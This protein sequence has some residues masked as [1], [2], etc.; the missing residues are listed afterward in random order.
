MKDEMM[1]LRSSIDGKRD[2]TSPDQHD[3][4]ILMFDN[5][6]HLGTATIFTEFIAYNLET[7]SEEKMQDIKNIAVPY[8]SVGLLEV[9]W[10]PLAGP[11]EEDKGKAPLD[12]DGLDDLLGKPWT[13][14]L[15][16]KQAANL[17]VFCEQAFVEYDFFGETFTTEGTLC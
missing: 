15:S 2:Y 6:F 3:P 13:Y 14:E 5:D 11:N 8:N 1:K 17:P 4:I 7:D 10:K 12:I 9:L 16:I